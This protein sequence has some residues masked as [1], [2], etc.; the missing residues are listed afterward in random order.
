M[1]L[2]LITF[3][4]LAAMSTLAF[5][6]H[7]SGNYRCTAHD[8]MSKVTYK[9][10]LKIAQSKVN[11][12]LYDLTWHF[13]DGK[14]TKATGFTQQVGRYETLNAIYLSKRQ[15]PHVKKKDHSGM[16]TYNIKGHDLMNGKWFFMDSD[17]IGSE[18]CVAS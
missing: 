5:A 11:P 13:T 6:N 15:A 10:T 1:I 17:V 12:K 16:V 2:K 18:Q 8:P 14:S 7:I 3:T 4:A 9:S